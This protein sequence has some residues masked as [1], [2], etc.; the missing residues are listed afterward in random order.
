MFCPRCGNEVADDQNFC[1]HCGA[2]LAQER[3]GTAESV[4]PEAEVSEAGREKTPWEDRGAKGFFSG[5]FTTLNQVLFSPSAFFRKM[6]V[7][8]GL[9]DPLLFA[10]IV[11]M[12]GL[13][14][15]YLW[16]FV[17]RGAIQDMVPIAGMQIGGD[18]VFHGI[19][20]ALLAFFSP[21]LIIIGLFVLAG[22]LHVCL[23]MV[24]GANQGFE[25]TF[26]V[27]AYGYSANIFMIIPVC[28]NL[29]A[30]A[31]ALVL[32]IIGLREA[33]RTSGGKA[34]FAVFLPVIFCCGLL[35]FG[36]ALFLGAAAGSLGSI[37]QMQQ[38]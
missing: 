10:L 25:A 20:L 15:S 23:M 26:R 28:G 35:L 24:K 9:T 13:M 37:I 4:P 30:A 34:S 5:L 14:F 36:T 7:T 19:G 1:H 29:I 31:W 16:R 22:V 17:L 21:F 12:T 8:G 11:G 2:R 6:P 32:Y 18:S 3:A 38:Q 33:H 27:A